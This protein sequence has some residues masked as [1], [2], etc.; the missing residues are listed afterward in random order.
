MRTAYFHAEDILLAQ[1]EKKTDVA[2]ASR[3]AIADIANTFH[4]KMYIKSKSADKVSS[5]IPCVVFFAYIMS[6]PLIA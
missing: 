3:S 6:K 2:I 1:N 4:D 5:N